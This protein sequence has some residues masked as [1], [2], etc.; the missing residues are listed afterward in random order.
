MLLGCLEPPE[1][2]GGVPVPIEE[3]NRLAGI[4]QH[5]LSRQALGLGDVPAHNRYYNLCPNRHCCENSATRSSVADP[6][7]F[8]T[9]SDLGK[10]HIRY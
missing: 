5:V 6:Y 4:V 3:L 1:G 8:F 9:D 7:Y 10:E 2:V